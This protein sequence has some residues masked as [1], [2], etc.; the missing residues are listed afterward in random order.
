MQRMSLV[1]AAAS[2]LVGAVVLN[3]VM[4]SL[5][6]PA[7]GQL[8]AGALLVGIRRV[9]HYIRRILERSSSASTEIEGYEGFGLPWYTMLVYGTFL[10]AAAVQAAG[11]VAGVSVALA[12]GNVSDLRAV[13]L[14]DI[15][16]GASAALFFVGAWLGSRVTQFGIPVLFAVVVLGRVIVAVIDYLALSKS[17]FEEVTGLEKSLSTF[18][19]TALGGSALFVGLAA[20]FGLVGFWHGRRSRLA[21]Y[22]HSLLGQVSEDTRQTIVNL[23]YEEAQR[24]EAKHM[25]APPKPAG[26]VPGSF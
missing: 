5:D 26:A 4:A 8:S 16:L 1:L 2:V 19:L 7:L 20:I 22:L 14:V 23:A 9:D 15:I 12:Q 25:P 17:Q 21:N 6:V 10:F 3:R 18:A 13:L 11:F 24:A